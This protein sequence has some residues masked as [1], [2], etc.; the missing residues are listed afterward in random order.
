MLIGLLNLHLESWDVSGAFLLAPHSGPQVRLSVPK[1]IPKKYLPPN[2]IPDEL[3]LL[4]I[5]AIY[6]LDTSPRSWFLYCRKKLLELGYIQLWECLYLKL[7]PRL[8]ILV[9]H[10]DD[11]TGAFQDKETAEM[12]R[13]A[14]SK[15]LPITVNYEDKQTILGFLFKRSETALEVSSPNLITLLLE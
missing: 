8:S 4:V 13:A 9:L 2:T 7:K 14:V 10:V 5:Q 11:F 3:L 12:E 1:Y 6:G 15:V